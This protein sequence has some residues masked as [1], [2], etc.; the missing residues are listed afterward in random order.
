MWNDNKMQYFMGLEKHVVRKYTNWFLSVLHVEVDPFKIW[1]LAIMGIPSAETRVLYNCLIHAMRVRVNPRHQMPQEQ[2]IR[3]TES[4]L[5]NKIHKAL[6]IR[7]SQ[8]LWDDNFFSTW[9]QN[10]KRRHLNDRNH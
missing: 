5:Q 4:P 2:A 6:L 9:Y 8:K 7:G 3:K 10:I 1:N